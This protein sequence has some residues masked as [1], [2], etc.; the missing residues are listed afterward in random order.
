MV[1]ADS[2]ITR[3]RKVE[4][5]NF[6]RFTHLVI[7]EIPESAKLVLLIGSNGSGKS[8]V[9]DAF[10][11]INSKRKK[12]RVALEYYRKTSS[13]KLE[14]G[15]RLSDGTTVRTNENSPVMISGNGV[16]AV[17]G[18]NALLYGRTSF[19]QL[20][21]LTRT[22]LGGDGKIDL[23]SDSDRPRYFIDKDNRFEN[24]IEKITET[25]LRDIFRSNNSKEQIRGKY[26]Q[27][28]NRALSNVFGSQEGSRLELI[29]I[30]PPLD[31]KVAQINFRKGVSEIH[32]D[33]LSA[34]EKEVVNILFNLLSR[35]PLY[36]ESVY[37]FD[38][39]DLHLNTKYQFA[40]L[41]EITENWIPDNCQFWTASHSLGFIEYARQADHAVI[42]DF[43]D[44]DFDQPQVL[45][46][47]TKDSPNIFE[48]AV[49]K[50]L[51]PTLFQGKRIV[52]VE[53]TDAILYNSLGLS[54]DVFVSANDRNN[55]FYKVISSPDFHGVVDR[56]FLTD[57]EIPMIRKEYPQLHIL[58][59]YSIENYLYHP[60]NL[61]DFF[62]S[63][64]KEFDKDGYIQAIVTEKNAVKGRIVI[65]I[66]LSRAGYPYF[67]E[68]RFNNREQQKRFS[69]KEENSTA[70]DEIGRC[71]DS[72]KLEIFFKVLPM[73]TY[74]KALPQRQNIERVKLAKTKWFKDRLAEVLGR[75]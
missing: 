73:K 54:S 40:L 72:D 35:G 24:D 19:R 32:Y 13:T 65:D 29:E 74:C 68:E 69:N 39:I 42:I 37:Y 2:P 17:L 8:S 15:I 14:V 21:R 62:N 6:K 75:C 55:V 47:A 16:T 70:S 53:N 20:P 30:L 46:P 63:E 1:Q 33:F 23:K 22:K 61:A 9:F 25:I 18:S 5:Q 10:E 59:Y 51:L 3:I 11:F 52:F 4:L 12:E 71:L 64:G 34:G 26:I 57:E 28:I 7:D 36:N 44:L 48:I 41:K 38:E 58:G 31:G 45:T 56:D 50:E 66:K 49:N 67:K 60:D 43:D 27:P